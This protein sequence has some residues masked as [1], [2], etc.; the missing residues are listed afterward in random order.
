LTLVESM[1]D[2][3]K[4]LRDLSWHYK[5]E[6]DNNGAEQV[7]AQ[8]ELRM[9]VGTTKALGETLDLMSDNAEM[10]IK[11]SDDRGYWT[12]NITERFQ[13]YGKEYKKCKSIAQRLIDCYLLKFDKEEV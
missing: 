8:A 11:F 3:S 12:T 7:L 9:H 2:L 13:R 6:I 4:V 10:M 1:R 5:Y